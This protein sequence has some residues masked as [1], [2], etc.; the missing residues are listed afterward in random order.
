MPKIWIY[1]DSYNKQEFV[2]KSILPKTTCGPKLFL[3]QVTFFNCD[4]NSKN[5][6]Y[7]QS[8]L[9]SI[10][11]QQKL[12]IKYH[13][14][15]E[16]G[17]FSYKRGSKLKTALYLSNEVKDLF[18]VKVNISQIENINTEECI[19]DIYKK[20]KQTKNSNCAGFAKI[21]LSCKYLSKNNQLTLQL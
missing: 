21:C 12:I 5:K 11:Q 15:K 18:K 20:G 17:H 14:D 16:L 6:K 13:I 7:I 19:Y 3:S 4:I 2:F 10:K 9:K 1:L 8:L